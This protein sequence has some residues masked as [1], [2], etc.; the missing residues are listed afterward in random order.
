MDNLFYSRG[1]RFDS[2]NSDHLNSEIQSYNE[3]LSHLKSQLRTHNDEQRNKI[4]ILQQENAIKTDEN[5]QLKQQLSIY[6][7]R[8]M[9]KN[10]QIEILK[11]KLDKN[12][13]HITTEYIINEQ[14]QQINQL[15]TKLQSAQSQLKQCKMEIAES[16]TRSKDF[17]NV[18]DALYFLFNVVRARY[19]GWAI[20]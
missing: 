19:D 9:D 6:E 10:E 17:A 1:D 3:K 4:R 11:N 7:K 16:N 15:D 18:Y 13:H 12:V 2:V 5:M 20:T 8:L 14:R